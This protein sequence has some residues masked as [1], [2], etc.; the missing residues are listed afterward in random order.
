MC[1]M[2]YGALFW[3]TYRPIWALGMEGPWSLA[4]ARLSFH[5]LQE[6]RTCAAIYGVAWSEESGELS[7]KVTFGCY[8]F[9]LVRSFSLGRLACSLAQWVAQNE[10]VPDVHYGPHIP[11]TKQNYICRCCRHTLD[12]PVLTS[13]L[14]SHRPDFQ[15]GRI[16]HW[17]EP[18]TC[19]SLNLSDLVRLT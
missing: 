11:G 2:E 3:G 9:A 18:W 15:E 6:G 19:S 12:W 4:S 7:L 14:R 17:L 10:I 8:V 5:H 16:S 13:H 1:K